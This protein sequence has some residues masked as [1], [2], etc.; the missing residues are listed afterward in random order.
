MELVSDIS[1]IRG[2]EELFDRAAHLFVAATDIAC[3]ADDLYTWAVSR[4]SLARHGERL[5]QEKRVRKLYRPGVLLN[6]ATA[7]HLHHMSDLGAQIRIGTEDIN[8][9]ILLD[10]RVAIMA[11]DGTKE[12]RTYSVISRPELV[13]GILSLYEAAW[14][15]ATTLETFDAR[16]A[17][18]REEAPHILEFLTTGCKDEQAAKALGMGLRTYRRRVSELLV[19]LGVTSRVQ[20]EAR[21]QELGLL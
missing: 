10:E 21:A 9:T 5:V 19:A 7:E 14:Q 20:V 16:F 17:D 1:L 4:P 15:V 12:I 2:E 3:A 13:Q 18:I 6:E 11:G 8:E